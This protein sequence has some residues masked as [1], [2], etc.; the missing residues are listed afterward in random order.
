MSFG[1]DPRV[2]VTIHCHV[3]GWGVGGGVP[4]EAC[5]M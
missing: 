4:L 1:L 3:Q 5:N 2:G